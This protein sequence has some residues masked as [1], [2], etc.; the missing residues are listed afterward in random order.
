[1]SLRKRQ[2]DPTIT[3]PTA[4]GPGDPSAVGLDPSALGDPGAQAAPAAGPPDLGGGAPPQ[5]AG[6]LSPD[7]L[8]SIDLSAAGGADAGGA[9]MDPS[10]DPSAQDP[11]VMALFQAAMQGDP[12]AQQILE[13]A[14][15][16]NIA[17]V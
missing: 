8:Q 3:D 7:A 14:A 2:P 4:A 5:D 9:P 12:E 6:G 1:M 17:G 13:L 16:R 11:E 10:Q 15:R